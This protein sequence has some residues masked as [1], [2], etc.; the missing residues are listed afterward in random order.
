MGV[1]FVLL[2]ISF[3]VAFAL[4]NVKLLFLDSERHHIEVE[5]EAFFTQH[6]SY[7]ITIDD[8]L[9]KDDVRRGIDFGVRHFFNPKRQGWMVG[10]GL[11]TIEL[12][13]S[14]RILLELGIRQPITDPLFFQFNFNLQIVSLGTTTAFDPR[15]KFYLGYKLGG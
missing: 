12:E 15:Y 2:N 4:D 14:E 11:N 5:F 6:N 10:A 3:H 1:I 7:Y 9:A 8:R 13:N